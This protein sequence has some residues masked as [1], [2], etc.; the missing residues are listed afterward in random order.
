MLSNIRYI[1]ENDSVSLPG[2]DVDDTYI[3]SVGSSRYRKYNKDTLEQVTS[4]VSVVSG[5]VGI[6][7]L[8]SATAVIVSSSTNRID[9]VDVT[10]DTLIYSATTGVDA[11]HTSLYGSQIA[12]NPLLQTALVTTNSDGTLTRVASSGVCTTLSPSSLSGDQ[13]SCVIAK[14][15]TGGWT[16][17]W[18]IGTDSTK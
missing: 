4:D 9:F 13:A 16:S 10:S 14:E 11:V 17:K 2:I 3:Y 15:S 12:T 8:N 1:G 5:A 7:L 18:L 6:S